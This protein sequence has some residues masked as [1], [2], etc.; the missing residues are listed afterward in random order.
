MHYGLPQ[1]SVLGPS[2]FLLYINDLCSLTI[3]HCKIVSFADDTAL[4]F[5]GKSWDEVKIRTEKGL[6]KAFQ[7]L[8]LN[9]LTLNV[10]KTKFITFGITHRNIPKHQYKIRAHTCAYFSSNNPCECDYLSRECTIKYLGITLDQTLTWKPHIELLST[11]VR[12][13]IFLFKS[14]R[15][16]AEFK[17]L[18]TIYYAMAQSILTYCITS[19][20]GTSKTHLLTLE[21]AQR[22]LLKVMAFKPYRYPTK[23]LYAD[24]D[25]MTIRQMF[26]RDT[27][28]RQHKS[29]VF[30]HGLTLN[31]RKDK[32]FTVK[33]NRTFFINKFQCYL[34]P[35]LYNKLNKV[36]NIYECNVYKCK[37]I[38]T[39]WLKKQDYNEIE[40]LFIPLK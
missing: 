33:S 21:R 16:V 10:T 27:V 32:I 19:W 26:I 13:L 28:L 11:R 7:W 36:L 30:D 40:N 35:V 12:K 17:L 9:I 31:R 34:G 22:S 2:L 3:E 8:K 15:H 38:L 6:Y 25:I 37:Q 20:G 39:N 4:I 24:C 14:L 18:K 5:H 1:G 23:D 29:T